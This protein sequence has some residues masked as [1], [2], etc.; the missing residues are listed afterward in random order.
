MITKL[1]I[2]KNRYVD[3]VTL[4]QVRSKAMKTKGALTAEAQMATPANVEL[5]KE[6][7]FDVPADAAANDL[8]F[9]V[10]AETEEAAEAV[11][12]V[13]KGVLEG[14]AKEEKSSYASLD[15]IDLAATGFNLVQI[16]LPARSHFQFSQILVVDRRSVRSIFCC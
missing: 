16:S 12:Q 15:E 4:M 14:G 13:M 1:T 3:S 2:Q 8:V 9:G 10:A 11:L 7:G 5:M 6:L